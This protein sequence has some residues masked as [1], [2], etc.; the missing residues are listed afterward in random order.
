[1]SEHKPRYR[2]AEDDLR[3][4]I[5]MWCDGKVADEI[6][7][8]FGISARGVTKAIGRLRRQGVP[9]P[10]RGGW[11]PGRRQKP[12]TQEEVEY[13]IRRRN[14]RASSA[15]IAEELDRTDFAIS[16]MI[17]KL[18]QEGVNVRM[19]G[20]GTRRLWNAENLR[21]AMAGRMLRVVEDETEEAA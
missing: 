1:M 6:G 7:R 20:H 5:A 15:K 8:H 17:H 12:W 2:W 16:A 9:L 18:R 19:L 14:E 3:T 10:K 13:L 11:V 4:L 21:A